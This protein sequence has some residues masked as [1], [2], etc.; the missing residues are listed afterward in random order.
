MCVCTFVQV[1]FNLFLSLVSE[2]NEARKGGKK[3]L[4]SLSSYVTFEH[5]KIQKIQSTDNDVVKLYN[6]FQNLQSSFSSHFLLLSFVAYKRGIS[7]LE[8]NEEVV[9]EE[10]TGR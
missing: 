3:D 4:I 2:Y 9:R 8:G 6:R 7:K 1:F 5:R 10:K